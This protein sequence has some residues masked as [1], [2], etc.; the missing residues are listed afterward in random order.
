MKLKNVMPVVA[1]AGLL[2]APIAAQAG[3]AASAALPKAASLSGA[4][5]R[6]SAPVQA[7]QKAAP[8]VFILGA[9]ALGLAGWGIVEAA[10]SDNK[11]NGA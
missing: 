11:S 9:V 8:G 4:G 10:K 6:S 2:F 3:T 1:A 5:V 7:K